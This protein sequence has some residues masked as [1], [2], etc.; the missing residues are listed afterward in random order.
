MTDNNTFILELL[1]IF[2]WIGL[3]GIV[4]NLVDKYIEKDQYNV[5]IVLFAAMAFLALVMQMW[6]IKRNKNSY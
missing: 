2:L 1:Q 3:W 6:Y 5:R 4:D